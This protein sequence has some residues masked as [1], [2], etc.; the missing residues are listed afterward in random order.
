[1]AIT[2]SS[3]EKI[4]SVFV[5]INLLYPVAT[6]CLSTLRLY[7]IQ[8]GSATQPFPNWNPEDNYVGL[9]MR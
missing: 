7:S 4:P 3:L 9:N 1:M 2:C 5:V 6:I 8:V